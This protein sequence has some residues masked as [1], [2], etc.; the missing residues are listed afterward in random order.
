MRAE[1]YWIL[2][3]QVLWFNYTVVEMFSFIDSAI[4]QFIKSQKGPPPTP[5]EPIYPDIHC[6][7][8]AYIVRAGS[9]LWCETGS[10]WL[11]F[12]DEPV[13]VVAWS[14]RINVEWLMNWLAW[15]GGVGKDNRW[16]ASISI[17]WFC[18]SIQ[19]EEWAPDIYPNKEIGPV[20]LYKS[21]NLP[22]TCIQIQE[23]TADIYPNPGIYLGH[24]SKSRN[25]PRIYIQIQ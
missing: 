16:R 24:K 8:L 5:V 4:T 6:Y 11:R 19:I 14:E 2:S 20:D 25:L 12:A 21:R 1:C 9:G 3:N 10:N 17:N 18:K 15:L 22:Q 23:F 13:V 7:P